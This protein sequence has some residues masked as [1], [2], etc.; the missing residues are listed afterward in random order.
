MK[1]WR[2]IRDELGLTPVTSVSALGATERVL[3]RPLERSDC[4]PFLEMVR[5]S[6]DLHHP[7]AYPP[8]RPD[9][10]ED[11]IARC[12]HADSECLL[13]CDRRTG[14]IAGVFT[15]SQ[16]I[17]GA[18]QSAYLGYYASAQYA[19]RGYMREAVALVIDYSFGPLGL[20]RLEA[21]IQPTNEASIALAIGAG[22][23]LEG[24]SPRYLLIAGRWRDHERYAI[25]REEHAEH[26]RRSKQVQLG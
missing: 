7:W 6:R 21:N 18:F 12:R 26:S 2:R 14:D 25:T 15:V 4:E 10:F 17:R 8:E 22:L 19:G 11:L 20:H 23:R 9:Q 16:I 3:L 13:A 1:G 24:Y 5:K